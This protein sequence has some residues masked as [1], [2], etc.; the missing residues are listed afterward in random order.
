MLCEY[1]QKSLDKNAQLKMTLKR[2]KYEVNGKECGILY[3]HTMIYE[4]QLDTDA[5]AETV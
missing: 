3:L 1:L 5:T 4:S 2:E